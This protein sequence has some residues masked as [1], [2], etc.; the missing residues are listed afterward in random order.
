VILIDA[1]NRGPGEPQW[2]RFGFLVADLFTALALLFL[3]ANTVGHVPPPVHSPPTPTWTPSICGLET[4]PVANVVLTFDGADGLRQFDP[5]AEQGFSQLV[6]ARLSA[7]AGR[8]A[9]LVEVFGGSYNG[10]LD[11]GD[12]LSLARGAIDSLSLLA[13]QQFIFTTDQTLYQPFWD[14][15]ISGTQIRIVLFLYTESTGQSCSV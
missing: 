2:G 8:T 5:A 12:G 10:N 11:V 4:K 3:V 14:G 9:G 6:Q 13:H 7:Y 1:P 15:T